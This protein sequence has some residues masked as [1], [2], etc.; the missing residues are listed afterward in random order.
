MSVTRR[1][2]VRAGITL[3]L[4][5]AAAPALGAQMPGMPEMKRM[6]SWEP[7]LFVLADQLEYAPNGVGRPVNLEI[8]SWYGGAINRVWVRPQAEIATSQRQGEF[9]TEVLYGRLVDPWWDAVVGLRVDTHWGSNDFTRVL[10]TVGLIGLARYRFEFEPTLFV[11]QKGELSARVQASTQILITQK[12]VAEPEFEVNAALQAVP[13]Y[14]I[15]SGLNDYEAGV[16]VRYEFRRE[17]APYVGWSSSRRVG[18]STDLPAPDGD[19]RS[20]NR[21]VVGLRLWR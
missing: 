2:L 1:P 20:E 21:L 17:I 5:L 3:A 7:T 11:S 16:R 18:G 6:M 9:E 19:P 13:D 4:L 10:A 8:L 15:R 14:D 12:L